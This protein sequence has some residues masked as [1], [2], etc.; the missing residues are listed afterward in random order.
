MADEDEGPIGREVPQHCVDCGCHPHRHWNPVRDKVCPRCGCPDLRTA[1]A[2]RDASGAS[3]HYAGA[4]RNSNP[5]F[6]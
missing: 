4:E 3:D 6:Y 2:Q 1:K 5:G